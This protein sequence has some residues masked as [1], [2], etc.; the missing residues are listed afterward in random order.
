MGG[1]HRSWKEPEGRRSSSKRPEMLRGKWTEGLGRPGEVA[2][3]HRDVEG[4]GKWPE[5]SGRP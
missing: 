5:E 3:G 4:R 1:N 2:S